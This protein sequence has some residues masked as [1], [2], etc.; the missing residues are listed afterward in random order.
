MAVRFA[1]GDGLHNGARLSAGPVPPS[2]QHGTANAYS[3]YRCR[4]GTCKAW[5]AGQSKLKRDR[6]RAR[7]LAALTRVNGLTRAE[8]KPGT[9]ILTAVCGNC[10]LLLVEDPHTLTWLHLT[11]R[12]VICPG[13]RLPDTNAPAR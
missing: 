1:H 13:Q 11:T 3:N 12:D 8:P 2:V 6:A 9:I 5:N 7:R 10:T 4:C